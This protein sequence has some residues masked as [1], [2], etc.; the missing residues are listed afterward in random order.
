MNII[1]QLIIGS[2]MIGCVYSVLGMGY[3]LIYKATGLMNL[4]QGEFLMAGAYV[5]YTFKV[6]LGLPY[7]AAIIATFVV[8]FLIGFFIQG[9]IVS[10]LLNRGCQFAYV[11]LCTA[12]ISMLLQNS[13]LLAF[14]AETMVIPKSFAT[15]SVK[16]LGCNVSPEYLLVVALAIVCALALH[17]FLNKTKFGTA[18]RAAAL[19]PKAAS[20]MG[21]NVPMTKCVVWGL[22]AALSGVAGCAIGP[23]YGVYVLLGGLIGQKAFAGAVVGG[24]GNMYGAIIGGLF[25]GFLENFTAAFITTAYKDLISFAVLI[26]VITFMPTGILKEKVLE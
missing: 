4:A 19:N 7:W 26:L 25:F 11:I 15:A 21:I 24:Y 20:A 13:A 17:L 5:G 8:M 6:L 16:I 2:L 3:S 1:I 22:S 14:T 12:A 23:I 9:G 18:M 10:P